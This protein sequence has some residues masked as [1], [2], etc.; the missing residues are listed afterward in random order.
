MNQFQQVRFSPFALA[1]SLRKSFT[2]SNS[3][4]TSCTQF[5]CWYITRHTM[6]ECLRVGH[7]WSASTNSRHSSQYE[8]LLKLLDVDRFQ[9]YHAPTSTASLSYTRVISTGTYFWRTSL[10]IQSQQV[11]CHVSGSC[12]RCHYNNFV[13]KIL[14]K[15]KLTQL[16]AYRKARKKRWI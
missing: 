1:P 7:N 11:A 16:W 13:Q 15:Y 4:I 14:T 3:R 5:I 2:C 9:P 8:S 10:E 6:Q 12:S